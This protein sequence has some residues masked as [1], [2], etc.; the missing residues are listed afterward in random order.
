[1]KSKTLRRTALILA[2]VVILAL[3]PFIYSR[4]VW[5][6]S[7]AA[8]WFCWQLRASGRDSM[9]DGG[10]AWLAERAS[11]NAGPVTPPTDLTCAIEQRS[12]SSAEGDMPYFVLNEQDSPS[13]LL[14]YFA[15]GTYI[16]PPSATHWYFIDELA[17]RTGA[18]VIV[19][20]YPLLPEA[21]AEECLAVL[22]PFYTEIVTAMDCGTLAFGGDSAGGG[23]ALSTAQVLAA[24][25]ADGPDRLLLISPWL[26]V[27]M[28]NE[29]LSAYE[30]A[31]PKLDRETLR[32]AGSLR[33]GD[34]DVTDP[35]VSPLYGDC[36]GLGDILLMAGTRELLYPDIL[37]FSALL[38]EQGVDHS[39]Y[40]G[41]GMNHIWPLF[42]H[43]GLPEAAEALD[44]AVAFLTA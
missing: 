20:V 15:G 39:L 31:D 14:V 21:D 41:E 33:A 22:R 38:D 24:E 6:R 29:E 28:E 10:E 32:F 36:S 25:G 27:S 9:P 12:F 30:A 34:L 3:S 4:L 35:L 1:M 16:D 23:L 18:E 42:A 37:R 19:P 2:L 44:A 13:L 17:A 26:D 7:V 5:H 43:Y 11:V 8:T 40:I